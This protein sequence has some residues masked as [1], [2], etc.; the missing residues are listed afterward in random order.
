MISTLSSAPN[1]AF[2]FPISANQAIT[3]AQLG[4]KVSTELTGNPPL[5]V[6]RRPWPNGQGEDIYVNNAKITLSKSNYQYINA[7]QKQVTIILCCT[8]YSVIIL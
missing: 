3:L 6:T 8:F 7:K 1:L 5:W 2:P 4:S